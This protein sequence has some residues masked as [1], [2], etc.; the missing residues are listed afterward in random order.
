[1]RQAKI[2]LGVAP[3]HRN[4]AS[5]PLERGL[6]YKGEIYKRLQQLGIEYVDIEDACPNGLLS[7]N[8]DVAAAEKKFKA[9]EID[10][11]FV[12][13]IDFGSE[14][15]TCQLAAKLGV[16]VLM[17]GPRDMT[18]Q[19]NDGDIQCGMI[20]AG[21]VFR[22]FS[23]PFTYVPTCF[24]EDTL[25][26]KGIKNFLAVANVVK[27]FRNCY[28]LQVG[29][30]P[31]SFWS[32]M[33]NEGELLEKFNIKIYPI[34]MT[35]IV[36]KTKE[37]LET[38]QADIDEMVEKL[39]QRANFTVLDEIVRKSVAL[40][41]ALDWYRKETLTTCCAFQCWYS[42]QAELGIWPCTAMS[43]LNEEGYPVICETDV[44]GAITCLLATAAT[45]GRTTPLFVDWCFRHPTIEHAE[46]VA[47]CGNCSMELF[48][49]KPNIGTRCFEFAKTMGGH[50]C[51]PVKQGEVSYFR[52]DGDQ[53]G[54]SMLLGTAKAFEEGDTCKRGARLWLDMPD[55]REFE[56]HVVYGP[57]IHHCAIIHEDIT[58]VMLEA[59]KYM[60][61][62]A[63]FT[64][65]AQKKAAEN[66]LMV[67]SMPNGPEG[68]V[69]TPGEPMII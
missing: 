61:V 30:R 50:V 8:P 33:C 41:F 40:K 23:I 53:N 14:G 28:V 15:A 21:K 69:V 43:L 27:T 66:Y 44:H 58:P 32:V 25:F 64:Y 46:F 35:E 2:R 5:F 18:A 4:D 51:G 20:A 12:P 68:L 63:D 24:I 1:M 13:F 59:A 9:C 16:P 29:P 31:E 57:Y 37:M 49:D 54:Y 48:Q 22:R 26:E 7:T 55:V 34:S 42:L 19:G 60:G 6:Y 56:K 10:A 62:E 52:F 17:W 36:S 45:M 65:E 3:T 38:R 39:R 67:E 11:L 47:H